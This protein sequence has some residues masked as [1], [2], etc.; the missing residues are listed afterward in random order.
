MMTR[1]AFAVCLVANLLRSAGVGALVYRTCIYTDDNCK[2]CNV[3]ERSL[4]SVLVA[5]VAL[6]NAPAMHCA[7]SA[8][9]NG[10]CVTGAEQSKYHKPELGWSYE[11]EQQFGGEVDVKA[12]DYERCDLYNAARDKAWEENNDSLPPPDGPFSP[13]PP[14]DPYEVVCIAYDMNELAYVGGYLGTQCIDTRGGACFV[15]SSMAG[16]VL[17]MSVSWALP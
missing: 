7:G 14:R 8:V 11:E 12:A 16:L 6:M 13:P 10:T 1:T 5:N 3:V 17:A 15:C 4:F 2:L 9:V